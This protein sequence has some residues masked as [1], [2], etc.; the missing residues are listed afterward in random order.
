[1]DLKVKSFSILI[2]L[3]CLPFFAQNN[4]PNESTQDTIQNIVYSEQNND[5]IYIYKNRITA[6][7]FF[8]KTS[9]SLRIRDRND[10][11]NEFH[12]YP[13]NQDKIGASVAFRSISA[14]YS[15]ST[16]SLAENPEDK[17]SKLLN[18]NLRTYFG[19][20]FMQTL[21]IYSQVG[22]QLEGT[23][24]Q[25]A[26]LPKTKSFKIGGSTSYIFNENFSYRAIAT[27]DEKQLK[28]AGTFMPRLV[29]YFTKYDLNFPDINLSNDYN[30]FDIAFAPAYIY[31]FVPTKNLFISAGASAGIGLNYSN[32]PHGDD[33]LT[34][35]L[36]ELDFSGTI[37]YDV[38]YLYL[39][40]HYN[41]L[42]LNHNTDRSSYI[43]DD[44]PYLQFF[45][46]YR[47]NAPKKIVNKADEI[48]KKIGF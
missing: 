17:D 34:S 9:N 10:S 28:S 12:L 41:Y 45:I 7:A 20:H 37:T 47:F 39:G 2:N 33:D 30:S 23:N 6:R 44:I 26:Y 42:I 25:P 29:Y 19:K 36:T 48:N 43:K 27:Q 40:A 15:F 3:L 22:F 31:N 4:I 13:N 35:L 8:V 1:M 21:D 46:G 24:Y 18:F 11:N 32:N 38:N 16:K 14:S 5:Y